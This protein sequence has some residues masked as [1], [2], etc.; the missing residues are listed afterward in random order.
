MVRLNAQRV[1]ELLKLLAAE[2]NDCFLRY[3]LAREYMKGDRLDAALEQLN[4]IFRIDPNYAAAYF[5]C[6]HALVR[7]GN[8]AAAREKYEAGIPVAE[9]SGDAHLAGQMREALELLDQ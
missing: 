2:P 3:G 9:K 8:V 7:Q 4:A 5:A 1:E 6:G